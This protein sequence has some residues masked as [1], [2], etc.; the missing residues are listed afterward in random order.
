MD[1]TQSKVDKDSQ[2]F[3]DAMR[4]IWG[5]TWGKFRDINGKDDFQKT[6]APDM[7]KGQASKEQRN[8]AEQE[9]AAVRRLITR[10]ISSLQFAN[11]KITKISEALTSGS[12]SNEENNRNNNSIFAR[13]PQNNNSISKREDNNSN[14]QNS[15]KTNSRAF[16]SGSGESSSSDES[17]GDGE[18]DSAD[19]SGNSGRRRR[20]RKS[21]RMQRSE[22]NDSN[23]NNNGTN[24]NNLH[25][26]ADLQNLKQKI[27]D[28]ENKS[29]VWES[30]IQSLKGKSQAVDPQSAE[31]SYELQLQ[32]RKKNNLVFFG[33]QGDEQ[34]DINQLKALFSDLGADVYLDNTKFFRTGR[35]LEKCRPLILKLENQE[36]KAKILFN[37]KKLKNNKT[38]TGVSITHDLTKQ[39]CQTEKLKEMELRKEAVEKNSRLSK[40]EKNTRVWKVVGGRGTRCLV[41][42]NKEAPP[43]QGGL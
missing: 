25:T 13:S 34:D 22:K 2:S 6:S 5:P 29:A 16:S 10:S 38:W 26:D 20:R 21:K 39:Q 4:M 36:E 37:A 8:G 17:S 31:T 7:N 35:S 19:N 32:E 14:S 3:D 24:S 40:E 1:N 28:L 41:L 30:Q 18:R 27:K 9:L 12:L 11:D 33:L 42:R 43:N 15:N 23:K